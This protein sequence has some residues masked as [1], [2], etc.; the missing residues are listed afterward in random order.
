MSENANRQASEPD[1]AP[2]EAE[3]ARRSIREARDEVEREL[4]V[5]KHCFP[6]WVDVGKLSR[7]DAVDRIARLESALYHLS[8]LCDLS[9]DS[10]G[11]P[12]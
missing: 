3:A 4:N 2:P 10:P 12:F 6:R 7:T 9:D 5:R 1:V 8:K 11:K